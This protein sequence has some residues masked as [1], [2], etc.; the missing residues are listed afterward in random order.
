MQG[1]IMLGCIGVV[2]VYLLY[3]EFQVIEE[4]RV[5]KEETENSGG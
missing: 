1:L 2:V 3:K 5:E 4:E